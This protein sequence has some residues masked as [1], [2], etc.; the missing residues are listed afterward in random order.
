MLCI[1]RGPDGE[2]S[3]KIMIA[4]NDKRAFVNVP[5]SVRPADGS[6]HWARSDLFRYDK[7]FFER[8]SSAHREDKQEELNQLWDAARPVFRTTAISPPSNEAISWSE[9]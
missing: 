5:G 2:P 1:A 7:E 3:L 4:F 8:I 6:Q 9:P